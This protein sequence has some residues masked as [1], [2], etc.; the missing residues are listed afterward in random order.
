MYVLIHQMQILGA[1]W[2]K[3]FLKAAVS[4]KIIFESVVFLI[5]IPKVKVG[6]L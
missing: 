6:L 1:Y 3:P 4:Q 2:K 5:K